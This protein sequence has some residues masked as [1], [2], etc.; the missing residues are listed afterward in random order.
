MFQISYQKSKYKIVVEPYCIED[1]TPDKLTYWFI[2]SFILYL[3]FKI[4]KKI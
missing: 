1:S 4:D 2:Q 3:V